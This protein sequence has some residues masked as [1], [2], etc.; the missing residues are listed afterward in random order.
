MRVDEMEWARRQNSVACP[1]YPQ[2]SQAMPANSTGTKK[3]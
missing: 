3:Q 2:A 1:R